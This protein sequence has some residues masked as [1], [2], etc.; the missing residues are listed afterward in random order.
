MFEMRGITKDF[1]AVKALKGASLSVRPGEIRSLLG[2][3]G[4]GKSTLVKV[5]AGL[6]KPDGGEVFIDGKPVRIRTSYDSKQL[7]IATAFQD[8]SLIPTMTV[9]DNIKLNKE[10][11]GRFGTIDVKKDRRDVEELL[12][13]FRVRCDLDAYA[14]TLMPSTQSM[15]E[16]AK[17][18]YAKP[19]LLLLDEVTATL[20]HD[21]IEGLF[22]LL[23]KLRDEGTA[24][25]Y[26]TH[27]M[28]E[29]AKLC[30]S[31]TIMRNGETVAELARDELNDLDGIVYHMTGKVPDKAK[32]CGAQ[33]AAAEGEA[34][35][36]VSGLK[37]SP[38][39][40]DLSLTAY[41]GE[42]L[43]IGGLDG[44]GQSEFIRL[45]LGEF[46]PEAGA[47]RY[48]GKEV[49][50]RRPA[51]AVENGIG[52]ISGERNREAIFPLRTI[53]ENL[54]VGRTATGGLFKFIGNRRV[55]GF[56]REA[57]EKYNI[58]VGELEDPASSLSGGNQ[59]KLI[60][61]RELSRSP[62]VIVANKPTRG[63]DIGAAAFVHQKLLEERERGTGI[64][65]IS[66]DLDEILLLSDRILVIFNGQS[67]GV[68]NSGDADTQT[69]GLMMAGT[70]LA[71]LTAQ[72]AAS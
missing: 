71:D 23:R 16:V 57:V 53:A 15:L 42:I 9:I 58:K 24:I 47:I 44:Q 68:L 13:L 26:V 33:A 22:E 19:R 7:G 30:D 10:T 56:A 37:Y 59:Q 17:A 41:K 64:L 29:V 45:L 6:V 34:L 18:V 35:L 28:K 20:H 50:F 1:D 25:V 63:L 62:R 11:V 66:S 8:L 14:Q 3:N 49:R 65:L 4:S 48:R 40:R 54:F 2:A 31:A 55:N 46:Q 60:L 51:E 43:G 36:E 27:R 52:F 39:V 72:E 32:A 70:P 67:M 61:A 12:K 69:L 21:E 38:K 5:L